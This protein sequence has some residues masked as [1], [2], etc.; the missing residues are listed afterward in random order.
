MYIVPNFNDLTDN[1][2]G[3]LTVLKKDDERSQ[4]TKRT[5]WLCKCKCGNVVSVRSDMLGVKT[6]S[7][8]CLKKE[9]DGKNLGRFTTG[10]SHS[11]LASTWYHIK[12][13]CYN[14]K[15]NLYE[16]Y[17]GRG[18][19]VCDEWRDDFIK[20]KEWAINNGYSDD[21]TIDRIDVD[22]NYEPT[23]CRWATLQDQL[24]NKRN[25]LWI[26]H[27]GKWKSLAEAYKE[28]ETTVTYQTVRER[29]HNGIREV[30]ELFKDRQYRGKQGY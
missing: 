19:S 12:A 4:K 21:L 3:R 11:R 13:R 30:K 28:E 23:N 25:T 7:C 27:N 18:I 20:F 22:G 2:Y 1:N 29:Y 8:G 10:E 6:F 24:N 9:Q 17:G 14:P 15:Q 26:E 16:C 5:F